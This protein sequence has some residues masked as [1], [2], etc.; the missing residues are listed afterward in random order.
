M[1]DGGPAVSQGVESGVYKIH[2]SELVHGCNI[3]WV[4]VLKAE[5]KIVK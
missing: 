3:V 1:G 2:D 4:D 5:I